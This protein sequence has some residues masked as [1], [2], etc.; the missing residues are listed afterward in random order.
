MPSPPIIVSAPTFPS[1]RSLPSK[2]V[3]MLLPLLPV[4]RLLRALPVPLISALP[5][6]VRFSRLA[7]RE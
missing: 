6:R 7:P 4:I 5:T 3:R 2:P 1:K